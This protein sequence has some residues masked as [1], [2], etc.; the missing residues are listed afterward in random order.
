MLEIKTQVKNIAVAL[1]VVLTGITFGILFS[2]N[3]KQ[4][5]NYQSGQ[6]SQAQVEG[7]NTTPDNQS[8]NAIDSTHSQKNQ[9]A[10]VTR[11]VDGDTIEIEGGQKVRYIGIDTPET[12]DPRKA[13]QCFGQEAAAKNKELVEGKTVTLEKDISETDKYGRLLRYVHV[14]QIFVNDYLVREGYAHV[15]SYPPDIKYQDQFLEAQQEARENNRGLWSQCQSS[16]PITNQTS[17]NC[18]IKGNI[19]SSG[20]KIYHLPGQ[21]YY[22]Q[23]VIDQ[24]KG[25]RWFCTEEEAQNA[26]WRK[27]KI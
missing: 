14:N 9:E 16:Q 26:L 10:K 11:I 17:G 15:S 24:N 22:N 18:V 8:T 6:K 3:H 21:R 1:A 20:E 23:T 13:V 4:A 2:S 12:I 7:V 27:S 5:N 25:E 19:S